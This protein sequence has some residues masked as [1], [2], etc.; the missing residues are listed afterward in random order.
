MGNQSEN[1][2]HHIIPFSVYRNTAIALIV[3]TVLTVMFHEMKM[4][5]LAAPIAF[6]IASVKAGLVMLF[7]MGLK[8][9]NQ[10]NRVIFSLGFIFLVLLF[11]FCSLDIWT[12]VDVLN[13][14]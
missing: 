11:L 12:R 10:V 13:P 3:L 4:G 14:I 8:Y 6:L 9:E 5:P 1:H 2:S 7:F